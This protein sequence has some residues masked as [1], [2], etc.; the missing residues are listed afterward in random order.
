MSA[1]TYD[2]IVANIEQVSVDGA[3]VK[4]SWKCPVSGRII[5]S[6]TAWMTADPSITSRVGASV[7]RSIASEMIYGAARLVSGLI[8]GAVGRV[9]SN[10]VYTAA[11]DINTRAVAGVDYTEASRRDAIV[12]AFD[13]VKSSFEWNDSR[14]QFVATSAPSPPAANV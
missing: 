2:S 13:A 10:A 4:V 11:N 14:R 7:K 12:L 3:A 8:G 6:S 9:I 1:I 5:G